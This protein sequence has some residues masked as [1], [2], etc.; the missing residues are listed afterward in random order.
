MI[1]LICLGMHWGTLP[2]LWLK[3]G[4]AGWPSNGHCS[5]QRFRLVS[6]TAR[7]GGKQ[8]KIFRQKKKSPRHQ[9]IHP[10]A[11]VKHKPVI[12]CPSLIYIMFH[13]AFQWA[14]RPN[15]CLKRF[16]FPQTNLLAT[17]FPE[18]K[19]VRFA[20]GDRNSGSNTFWTKRSFWNEQTHTFRWGY[21]HQHIKHVA[22]PQNKQKV[23]FHL[24]HYE[25]LRTCLSVYQGD[26]CYRNTPATWRFARR[27]RV[28]ERAELRGNT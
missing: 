19:W 1:P 8:G 5:S 24:Y 25:P 20:H 12:A 26:M 27:R 7:P 2:T 17:N 3:G 22:T 10:M 23:K 21:V 9:R 11:V 16:I 18:F 28:C 15:A 6:V 13:N 14:E 4:A